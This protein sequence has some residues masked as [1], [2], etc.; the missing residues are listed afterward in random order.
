[1]ATI[2][3]FQSVTLDGVLQSPGRPDEDPRDGFRHGGW[4]GP[5]AD[6]V[7]LRFGAEGMA[8]DGALLFGRR[9]YTDVL[10]HWTTTSEPNPFTD[11]LLRTP[12]YVVTRSAATEPEFPATTLLAGDGVANVAAVKQQISGVLTIMGSGVLV[13]A[14]HAAGLIDDYLLLIHPIVLGSGRT[15]FG[16]G[17][18]RDLVLRRTEPTTTGV[19]V[20]HYAAH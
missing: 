20:A 8:R 15:L 13:R 11:V 17:E 12:K 3:L 2:T 4:A 14:L 10:R 1:M 16:P 5:Y 7:S 19:V 18:R 9:T 6:E